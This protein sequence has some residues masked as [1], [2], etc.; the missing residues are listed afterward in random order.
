VLTRERAAAAIE[1]LLDSEMFH[2]KRT[3][4]VP[5]LL[6]DWQFEEAEGEEPPA[7]R[8]AIERALA[9]LGFGV[10]GSRDQRD[11]TGDH[12]LSLLVARR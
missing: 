11:D 2:E 8:I 7:W 10:R 12:W 5:R 3:T 1:E 9:E 4:R 6:L